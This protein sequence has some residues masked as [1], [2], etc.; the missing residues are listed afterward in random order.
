MVRPRVYPANVWNAYRTDAL[1]RPSKA[2]WRNRLR[3][4]EATALRAREDARL[5]MRDVARRKQYE[6]SENM[7]RE[8]AEAAFGAILNSLDIAV[9]E[10]LLRRIT[11]T[12]AAG[13]RVT[14]PK[15]GTGKIAATA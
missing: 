5:A 8:L 2:A 15:N 14:I 9:P 13:K 12:T 11:F 7:L 4:D 6:I 3:L 10:N 1:N